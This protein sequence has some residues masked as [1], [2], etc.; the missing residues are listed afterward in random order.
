MIWQ[1]VL[2]PDSIIPLVGSKAQ[3]DPTISIFSDLATKIAPIVS[4]LEQF[5]TATWSDSI[6]HRLPSQTQPDVLNSLVQQT[7]AV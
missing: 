5:C 7:L 2:W 6:I 4:F 1:K 3:R